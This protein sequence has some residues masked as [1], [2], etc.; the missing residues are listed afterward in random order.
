MNDTSSMSRAPLTVADILAA[1]DAAEKVP[2]MLKEIRVHPDDFWAMKAFAVQ[3][4][5]EEPPPY[6]LP[7]PAGLGVEVVADWSRPLG[8]VELIDTRGEVMRTVRIR[9]KAEGKEGKP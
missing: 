9:S 2:A 7:F 1:V 8:E 5:A 4:K 3:K 6:A